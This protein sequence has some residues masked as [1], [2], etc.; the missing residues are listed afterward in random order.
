MPIPVSDP[1]S[2][3]EDT[4]LPTLSLALDPVPARHEF[5]RRLPWL[6]GPDGLVRLRGIRVVRHKPGRRCVI[7]YDV[8]VTRPNSPAEECTLIGKVRA[9]RFGAADYRLHQAIRN[10]GFGGDARD[11]IC[12]PEPVGFLARLH[13]WLQR[14]VAGRSA[15][16]LLGGGRDT[17]LARRIAE[18]A[19]KLHQA[20]VPTNRRHT[21]ADELRI[22]RDCLNI[23]AEH[24]PRWAIRIERLFAACQRVATALPNSVSCGIHRDFYADQVLANGAK[25]Y[26]LDFD[27]YCQGDPALDVGNFLGHLTEQ[28][29][30]TK[31]DADALRPVEQALDERFV[32][33][34][35]EAIRPAVS[36]YSLL[37]LARHVYLSTRFPERRAF[38]LQLLELCEHRAATFCRSEQPATAR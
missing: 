31:G 37:T 36:A 15:A 29:L 20:N 2:A 6:S 33:L 14:K 26:L 23:V 16:D 5:K 22:L 9:G 27:L 7:E 30:R 32:E 17:D 4:A 13:M 25:L 3:I 8:C 18:A 28:A 35:G 11:G 38:T 10:A 34:S 24:E 19:H 1:F 21:I 12:V